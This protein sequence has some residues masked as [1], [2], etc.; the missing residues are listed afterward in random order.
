M[1]I[2]LRKCL[3]WLRWREAFTANVSSNNNNWRPRLVVVC[4]NHLFSNN[5]RIRPRFATSTA[6]HRGREHFRAVRLSST[7]FHEKIAFRPIP[8]LLYCTVF[9]PLPL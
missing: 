5:D 1:D 4:S 7:F 3:K 8:L 2:M 6:T 9:T